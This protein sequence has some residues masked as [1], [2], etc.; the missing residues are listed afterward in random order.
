[1]LFCASF[2][3]ILVNLRLT[4]YGGDYAIGAYGIIVTM[5]SLFTMITVGVNMGMQPIAGYNFGAGKFDRAIRCYRLAVIA[6]TCITT[7][8][9]FL[10]EVFPKAVA[11]A[12]TSDPELI[13]Q[14]VVGMRI[15]VVLFPLIGFQMVTSSFFQSIDKARIA[16]FLTLSRQVLFLI[17]FLIVLP[18][19]WNLNGVWFA[20]PASDF[21]ATVVTYLVLRA[22]MKNRSTFC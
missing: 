18:L 19:I 1:M 12:F 20:G 3:S 9:F 6:A 15:G 4:G 7:V 10:G 22:Q 11:S 14:T 16:I 2:V 5:A 21:T 8:G 17:P 13:R